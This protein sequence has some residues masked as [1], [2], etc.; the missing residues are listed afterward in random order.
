MRHL[1]K[2]CR[3]ERRTAVMARLPPTEDCVEKKPAP[4]LVETDA[5]P[6]EVREGESAVDKRL[7]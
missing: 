1:G 3:R 5:A 6:S 2:V 4:V 7:D